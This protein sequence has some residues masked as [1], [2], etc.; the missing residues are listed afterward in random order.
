MSNYRH[1]SSATLDNYPGQTVTFRFGRQTILPRSDALRFGDG[2]GGTGLWTKGDPFDEVKPISRRAAANL[3]G[4]R[5][6]QPYCAGC[7]T[8]ATVALA[9]SSAASRSGKTKP[10]QLLCSRYIILAA[11]RSAFRL[12]A[13][14][15]D[16]GHFVRSGTRIIDASFEVWLG[17]GGQERRRLFKGL[18]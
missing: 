17:K 13:S 2:R 10:Y 7:N 15:Q 8:K 11:R 12:C 9:P 3:R 1:F 18:E 16:K 5:R 14:G 6:Q 4:L